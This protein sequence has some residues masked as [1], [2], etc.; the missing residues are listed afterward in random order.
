MTTW[1]RDARVFVVTMGTLILALA[2]GVAAIFIV[3][4]QLS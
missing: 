1:K 3:V 2:L 4:G